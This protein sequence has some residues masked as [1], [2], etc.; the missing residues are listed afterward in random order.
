MKA[1]S[2][3]AIVGGTPVGALMQLISVAALRY[4]GDGGEQMRTTRKIRA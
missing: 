4:Q 2:P 3:G 1:G